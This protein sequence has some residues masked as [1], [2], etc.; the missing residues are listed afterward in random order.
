M[1][2]FIHAYIHSFI[3]AFIH[4]IF[5]EHARYC[6]LATHHPCPRGAQSLVEGAGLVHVQR[7][8]CRVRNVSANHHQQK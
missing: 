8:E 4:Q 2:T 3:H 6:V 1:H 7:P 5:L